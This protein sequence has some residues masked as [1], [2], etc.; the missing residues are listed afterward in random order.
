MRHDGT[1]QSTHRALHVRHRYLSD[2]GRED[3]PGFEGDDQ[4]QTGAI[5]MV[6]HSI[7]TFVA[8]KSPGSSWQFLGY[9]GMSSTEISVDL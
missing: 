6:P 4:R 5:S 2:P 7:I 9:C 1:N 8:W 3:D